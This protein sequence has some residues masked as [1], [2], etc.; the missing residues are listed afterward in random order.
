MKKSFEKNLY[1]LSALA[2]EEK[3]VEEEGEALERL[4]IVIDWHIERAAKQQNTP[5]EVQEHIFSIQKEKQEIIDELRSELRCLDDPACHYEKKEL[6]RQ[7][8]YDVNENVF[9]YW[10]DRRQKRTASFGDVLTDLEWGIFYQFDA[11][12]PRGLQ[13]RYLLEKT[14][15]RLQCLL[16]NQIIENEGVREGLKTAYAGLKASHENIEKVGSGFISERIVKNIFKKLQWDNAAP[17]SISDADAYQDVEQ[18]ID[19]ILTRKEKRR[20]VGVETGG[21]LKNIGIQFTTN[22]HRVERKKQQVSFSKEQLVKEDKIDDIVLVIFPIRISKI[23][24]EKWKQRGRPSGGPN[25]FI[26]R[27][28]AEELFKSITKDVLSQEEI[29]SLW[30]SVSEKFPSNS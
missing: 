3:Q 8:T 13:R 25:Q 22:V 14:K 5:K 16:D 15:Y 24:Y 30:N 4:K 7:A 11:N 20:R 18:K 10:D 12:V 9:L 26:D 1:D 23:L 6:T 27:P 28:L 19:F 21:V 17:Y 29:D 2:K